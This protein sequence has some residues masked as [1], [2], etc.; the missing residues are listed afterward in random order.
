MKLARI[1][2]LARRSAARFIGYDD[3]SSAFRASLFCC[4]SG[5]EILEERNF[6]TGLEKRLL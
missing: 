3:V 2:E 4:L 5:T 1:I 6:R